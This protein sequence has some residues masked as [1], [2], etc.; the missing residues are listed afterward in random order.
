MIFSSNT[1]YTNCQPPESQP[2][3][4]QLYGGESD[5][6]W[7]GVVLRSKDGGTTLTRRIRELPLLGRGVT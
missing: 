5:G 4:S 2:I 1:T 3:G 7:R 6:R